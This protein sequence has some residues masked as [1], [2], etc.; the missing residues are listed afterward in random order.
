MKK[1]IISMALLGALALTSLAACSNS[2][3][4]DAQLENQNKDAYVS[5][6]LSSI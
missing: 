5:V 3:S 4:G 2:G 6:P 1:K